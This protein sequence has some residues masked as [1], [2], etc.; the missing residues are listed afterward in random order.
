M[1]SGRRGACPDAWDLQN[2]GADRPIAQVPPPFSLLLSHIFYYQGAPVR[3]SARG[4]KQRQNDLAPCWYPCRAKTKRS[5]RYN[6][7]GGCATI[8]QGRSAN[9][10]AFVRKSRKANY[11]C[12]KIDL[13]K[14]GT[15]TKEQ[16]R[17]WSCASNAE[18]EEGWKMESL[19]L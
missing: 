4:R 5:K 1:N 13:C 17:L 15:T 12:Q 8:R 19:W 7:F 6:H 16:I 2:F 18:S 11:R 9:N 10:W 14:I 3:P